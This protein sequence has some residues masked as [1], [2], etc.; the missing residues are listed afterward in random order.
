MTGQQPADDVTSKK[1]LCNRVKWRL[2]PFFLIFFVIVAVLLGV[3]R[4][5]DS[6]PAN[7]AASRHSNSRQ[8]YWF[9][10]KVFF[11]TGHNVSFQW[12]AVVL[13]LDLILLDDEGSVQC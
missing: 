12:P 10:V 5:R 7:D 4:F 3:Y 6:T 1:K 13:D 11:Q 8:V 9:H 2:I